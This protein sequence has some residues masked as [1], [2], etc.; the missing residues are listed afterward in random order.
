MP[1]KAWEKRLK[2][3]VEVCKKNV[4]YAKEELKEARDCVKNTCLDE[5]Y[6]CRWDG[7]SVPEGVWLKNAA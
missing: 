2:N 3:Y 6:E 4:D 5:V 7:R 1:Q